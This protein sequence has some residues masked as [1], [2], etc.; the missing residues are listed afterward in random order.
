[1]RRALLLLTA[2]LL[3]GCA[4]E[5]STDTSSAKAADGPKVD[6]LTEASCRHFRNVMGDIDVLTTDELRKKLKEVHEKGQYAEQ[7]GIPEASRAMLA[8][9]TQDNGE[10]LLQAAGDMDKACSAADS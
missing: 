5:A 1:M 6:V 10:A 3:T 7:S 2:L 9:A 4:T 8:A